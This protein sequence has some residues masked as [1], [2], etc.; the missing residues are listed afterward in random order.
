MKTIEITSNGFDYV[1]PV[2]S[3]SYL[4]PDMKAGGTWIELV[5]GTRL[6]TKININTLR[7]MLS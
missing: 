2:T 7:G 1:I 6:H 4:T 3:I 5:S